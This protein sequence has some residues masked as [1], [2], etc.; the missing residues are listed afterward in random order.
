MPKFEDKFEIKTFQLKSGIVDYSKKNMSNLCFIYF[1][2]IFYLTDPSKDIKISI[3]GNDVI[4]P[5]GK[6]IKTKVPNSSFSQSEYL[7]Y[8]ESQCRIRYLIKF[9][10]H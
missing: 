5:Q 2:T 4:V 10:L 6:P 7:V 8:K 1:F 9:K 3:D